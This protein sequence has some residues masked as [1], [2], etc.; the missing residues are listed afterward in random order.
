MMVKK[1]KVLI[2]VDSL[3]SGGTERQVIE[4]V[5]GFSK[6]KDF[7]VSVLTLTSNGYYDKIVKDYA[8]LYSLTAKPGDW[9]R[10]SSFNRLYKLIKG[11][12][13]DI[14]HTMSLE[15]S[16]MIYVLSKLLNF[17]WI[18]GSIRDADARLSRRQLQKRY[19]LKQSTYVISNSLA[20]LKV[21]NIKRR[22]FTKV[23]YNGVDPN[24]FIVKNISEYSKGAKEVRLCSVAN[25][26]SYK[27]Y[28]TIIEAVDSLR[29]LPITL[30]VFGDGPLRP[31]LETK[32]QEKGLQKKITFY[33]SVSNIEKFLPTMDCGVLM[34]FK[35]SG[36][37]LPNA[38]LEFMSSGVPA[39]AS[40][41]GG[42]SEVIKNNFNGILVE[43]ENASSLSEA[44]KRIVE[45]RGYLSFLSGNTLSVIQGKFTLGRMIDDY[46]SY[47]IEVV[48]G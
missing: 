9:K 5:K 11:N 16:L 44:I 17:K 31:Q 45:D 36:E 22:R 32:V 18:N 33:G 3:N 2:T 46:I 21:Y 6:N 39:I 27:D 26:T 25:L 48:H 19:L 15:D 10:V 4:L 28:N 12:S 38:I 7:E 29:E 41:V 20:G 14:I 8:S 34:S 30:H 42:V 13:F 23:I 40:N 1:V 37:G 35:K 24:R 47:Y 43:P